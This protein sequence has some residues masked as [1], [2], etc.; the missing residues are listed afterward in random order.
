MACRFGREEGSRKIETDSAKNYFVERAGE[1][2]CLKGGD[3]EK[4][5]AWEE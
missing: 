4:F 5:F 2:R 3:L 1:P